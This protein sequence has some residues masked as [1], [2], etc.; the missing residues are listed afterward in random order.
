VSASAVLRFSFALRALELGLYMPWK[1]PELLKRPCLEQ[2]YHY[3]DRLPM[4]GLYPVPL[5]LSGVGDESDVIV[6]KTKLQVPPFGGKSYEC[7][8]G[9]MAPTYCKIIRGVKPM[10]ASFHNGFYAQLQVSLLKLNPM[11]PIERC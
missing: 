2:L 5:G 9:K 10:G 7:R 4:F 6:K 8:T 11:T 1:A 3:P